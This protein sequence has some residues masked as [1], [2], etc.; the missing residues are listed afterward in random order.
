VPGDRA[1]LQKR[2]TFEDD[3][4]STAS[5]SKASPVRDQP[6]NTPA[7]SAAISFGAAVTK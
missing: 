4:S 7:S 5:T 2:Q 6:K 1:Q 3:A